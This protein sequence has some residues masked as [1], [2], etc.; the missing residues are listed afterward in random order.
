[1]NLLAILMLGIFG[2]FA[3][4]SSVAPSKKSSAA[5]SPSAKSASLSKYQRAH[6]ESLK[7]AAPA[8]RYFGRLK[9]SYLG[10][11]N[12][13]RDAAIMSGTHTTESGIISKVGFAEDALTDWER[14]F[15]HDPQLARTY[16]LAVQSEKKIWVKPNQERAWTYMNRLVKVFPATYFGKIVKKDLAVGFTE[17]YYANPVPCETPAPEPAQTPQPVAVA[18]PA[19]SRG[20][21]STPT[22]APTD[23]P[24]PSPAPEPSAAPTP[25]VKTLAK[26]LKVQIEI[27]A[28]VPPATP[29]PSPSPSPSPEASPAPAASAQPAT[30]QPATS[31]SPQPAA[32]TSPQPA[33]SATLQPAASASPQPAA[34]ASPPAQHSIA[35]RGV[36]GW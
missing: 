8:D 20:S 2:L 26:G 9:L 12:T 3:V 34:S 27:A 7:N 11:N 4:A 15:P 24:S 32:S 17:H 6:L 29:T 21:R 23:T 16:F 28:C 36:S 25:E 14:R 10:I 31:A 33:A 1:M 18:T 30:P 5:T 19:P 35:A 22:P 13:L